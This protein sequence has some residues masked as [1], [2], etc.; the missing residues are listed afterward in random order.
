MPGKEPV[1]KNFPLS[2]WEKLKRTP[3]P[4]DPSKLC[5]SISFVESSF[6]EQREGGMHSAI[7]I[8][9][10][11]MTPVV[12]DTDG[13]M[14]VNIEKGDIPDD[15]IYWDKGG[16]HCYIWGD[17]GFI[18]YYAHLHQK[19]LKKPGERVRP[20]DLLGYVGVSGNSGTWKNQQEY[21]QRRGNATTCP[22][23]H[24]ALYRTIDGKKA[25]AINPYPYLK[26]SFSRIVTPRKKVVAIGIGTVIV[27]VGVGYLI[28]RL[29]KR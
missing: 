20:G 1:F 2:G 29:I 8:F 5:P 12:A 14:W 7:D 15:Y 27:L 21:E 26:E 23:L 11:L 19:P 16:W 17:D 10:N 28:W 6:Y 3:K 24:F 4:R 18:R 25:G 13:I 22:H 9:T